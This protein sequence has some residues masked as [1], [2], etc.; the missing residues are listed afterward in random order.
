MRILVEPSDYRI[1]NRGD[2]ASLHVALD[3]LHRIWPAAAIDV[4][5]D[6]PAAL[7]ALAPFAT[8]VPT[9]G[10]ASWTEHPLI[11]RRL[12]SA[13][14]RALPSLPVLVDAEVR[15]RWP[16]HARQRVAG[17]LR[18]RPGGAAELDAYFQSVTE[19]D[20]VVVAGMGGVTDAFTR[21]T[22][23]VL[24]TVALAARHGVPTAMMSQQ[25]GPLTPW[26]RHLTRPTL[27]AVGLIAL[28]EARV[29]VPLL[30]SL[31][32]DG[33]RLRV[34]GDDTVGFVHERR[35]AELGQGI[36]VN[37]RTSRYAGVDRAEAAPVGAAVRAAAAR[38]GA[39]LVALP[40]SGNPD[41]DDAGALA[42]LTGD[43][44]GPADPPVTDVA[45]FARRVASCRVVV[46]GSYHGAVFALAQGIP[47]VCLTNAPYYDQKFL[48]LADL[49]GPGCRLLRFGAGMENR[50]SGAIDGAWAEARELRGGLL[51]AAARQAEQGAAA[52]ADLANL[53][54]GTPAP[55]SRGRG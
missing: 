31:G 11:G 15:N 37:V 18:D 25:I 36:G 8:P 55:R 34:T 20:L 14:V 51:A 30:A 9:M 47:A 48:G 2:A 52:Y 45:G 23:G 54:T 40:V 5:T 35:G 28:R 41:E 22:L 13:L 24:A 21:Y 27:R 1:L 6:D 53:V 42:A 17:A 3:R 29:G 7:A 33:A 38:F 16:E 46:T 12:P 32:V 44:V 26:L 50:L 49:F 4:L 43:V 10:H 39:P 19:A